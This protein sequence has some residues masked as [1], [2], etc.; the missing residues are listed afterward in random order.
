MDHGMMANNGPILELPKPTSFDVQEVYRYYGAAAYFGQV[1]EK[2]MLH[3]AIVLKLTGKAEVTNA[4]VKKLFASF[5]VQTMGQLLNSARRSQ[6][7]DDGLAHDLISAC[8][9][10]NYLVHDFYF[11]HALDFMTRD[12]RKKMIDELIELTRIFAQAYPA[13]DS[14]SGPL[15]ANYGVTEEMVERVYNKISA[16]TKDGN[17][18][19]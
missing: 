1:L 7:L 17:G 12:G 18:T 10:R 9:K 14:V 8:R 4:L 5:E 19:I 11:V 15:W 2:S 16:Q 13:C 6:L 3:L